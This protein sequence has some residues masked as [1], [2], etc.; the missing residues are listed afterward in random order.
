MT[1]VEF[2]P[3]AG[4]RATQQFFDKVREAGA[5]ARA[6]RQLRDHL[7]GQA[8][9][10]AVRARGGSAMDAFKAHCASTIAAGSMLK[11]EVAAVFARGIADQD[12]RDRYWRYFG[13]FAEG[14]SF[15]VAVRVVECEYRYLR[16][17]GRRASGHR[18]TVAKEARLILRFCRRFAPRALEPFVFSPVDDTVKFPL[19][20]G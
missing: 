16:S 18:L 2:R 7:R 11:A 9:G 3:S 14:A 17:L 8:V 13:D 10:D 15:Y 6:E 5:R 19:A 20:Q 12:N 1:V 4:A